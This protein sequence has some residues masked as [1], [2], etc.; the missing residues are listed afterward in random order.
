MDRKL[1]YREGKGI[2]NPNESEFSVMPEAWLRMSAKNLFKEYGTLE[3]IMK[4]LKQFPNK[5]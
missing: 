2:M 4:Y 5:K 1:V 3:E